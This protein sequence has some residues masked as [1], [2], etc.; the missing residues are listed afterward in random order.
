M[1]ETGKQIGLIVLDRRDAQIGLLQGSNIKEIDTLSSKVPG[2]H[3][4]GGQS[5][6]RFDRII[7]EKKENFYKKISKRATEAFVKDTDNLDGILIGGPST[8]RKD[9]VRGDYLHH[10]IDN[11]II[12]QAD[13]SDTKDNG[14]KELVDRCQKSISQ[15][16]D[17]EQKQKIDEF[18]KRLRKDNKVEYGLDEVKESIEYGAVETLLISEDIEDYELINKL[19]QKTEEK[20]GETIMISTSRDKGNLFYEGFGGIGALLRYDY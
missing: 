9:F 16:E 5:Q 2:K 20:G 7:E 1:L 12:G 13:V 18:F 11:K 17:M 4:K 6:V 8:T 19:T 14:L 15:I 3:K 10:E